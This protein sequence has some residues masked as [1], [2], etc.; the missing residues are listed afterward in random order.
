MTAPHPTDRTLAALI[1]GRLNPIAAAEVRQHVDGCAR[2]QLRIG[3]AG[4]GLRPAAP[5]EA[6]PAPLPLLAP[7]AAALPEPGDVWRLAWDDTAVIALVV[8]AD[9]ARIAVDPLV[10]T[11]DADEWCAL[12]PPQATGGLGAIAVSVAMETT[13]PWAVLD[14]RIVHLHEVTPVNS[15]RRAFRRGEST[16]TPRG[17]AVSGG[18]DDRLPGLEQVTEDLSNLANATW[19]PTTTERSETRFDFDQ[20]SEAGIAVN[21]VLAIVRGAAATDAEADLI[22]A[23][24]GMRPA[25]APVDDALRRRIDQPRR[26]AAIRERARVAG[27]PEATV[28]LQLARAAEPQGAAARGTHGA[29]PDYDTILDRLLDA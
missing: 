6:V 24:T 4:E 25:P 20:L 15:L 3:A 11:A 13:V 18:L 19:A 14:S 23:A 5:L 22:E 27:Y 1:D 21:R 12:L 29:P 10:E 7:A 9:T 2:C 26:K 17:A 28:R 8:S 16:S